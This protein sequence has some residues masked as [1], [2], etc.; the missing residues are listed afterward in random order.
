M[1]SIRDEF[2][3]SNTELGWIPGSWFP[4]GNWAFPNSLQSVGPTLGQASLGP[5][6]AFLIVQLD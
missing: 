3:F 2:A 4:V 1:P 6:V 5:L